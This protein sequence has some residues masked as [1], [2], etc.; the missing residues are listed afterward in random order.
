VISRVF[1]FV[2][3]LLRR[4]SFYFFS[5]V[6]LP[7]PLRRSVFFLRRDDLLPANPSDTTFHDLVSGFFSVWDLAKKFF[8]PALGWLPLG[9]VGVFWVT[10]ITPLVLDALS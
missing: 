7:F 9:G 3:S 10:T 5:L 2:F 1:Q 4:V 8:F 6:F